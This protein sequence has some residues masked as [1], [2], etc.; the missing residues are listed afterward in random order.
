MAEG[1]LSGPAENSTVGLLTDDI[2]SRVY[3][4]G[5]KTWECSVDLARYLTRLIR[6]GALQ[7][8][9]QD[10]HIIEVR[11]PRRFTPGS[12]PLSEHYIYQAIL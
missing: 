9:H 4:G 10:M 7:L 6:N 1:D 11:L 8:Q 5:F 2:L 12:I 3:E